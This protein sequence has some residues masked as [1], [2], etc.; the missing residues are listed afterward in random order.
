MMLVSLVIKTTIFI[1][2]VLLKL[3]INTAVY[4]VNKI[5]GY[6]YYCFIGAGDGIKHSKM[7]TISSKYY[8]SL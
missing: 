5:S 2:V 4:Y 1:C 8:R 6:M 7:K 3:M